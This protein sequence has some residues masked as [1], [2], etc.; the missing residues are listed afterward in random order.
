MIE[1]VKVSTLLKSDNKEIV[2]QCVELYNSHI[3][4]IRN[5]LRV[6]AKISL[7]NVYVDR[8]L[9]LID[10]IVAENV[11][12]SRKIELDFL[13][14]L[15]IL[16]N[17]LDR[18]YHRQK[19]L[20]KAKDK[21]IDWL[22]V[23]GVAGVGKST[24]QYEINKYYESQEDLSIT[25]LFFDS[26]R[27]D[28]MEKFAITL[29]L[30][31]QIK[32]IGG[33]PLII[34]DSIDV[35]GFDRERQDLLNRVYDLTDVKVLSIGRRNESQE[36]INSFTDQYLTLLEYDDNQ[37]KEAIQKYHSEYSRVNNDLTTVVTDSFA[38]I[39]LNNKS[40]RDQFRD[41]LLMNMAFAAYAP[42]NI[43]I[44]GTLNRSS[45]YA[46]FWNKIVEHSR[47]DIG[48]GTTRSNLLKF[49]AYC[50]VMK[51]NDQQMKSDL[52][53]FSILPS[54]GEIFQDILDSLFS[55]NLIT[56]NSYDTVSFFHDSFLTYAA[57]RYIVEGRS[58]DEQVGLRNLLIQ[59]MFSKPNDNEFI[60]NTLV[61]Y[62][63]LLGKESKSEFEKLL[64]DN[65]SHESED[66]P[67]RFC[68]RF[69]L[70][71]W[72]E[73]VLRSGMDDHD[74]QKLIDVY[75]RYQFMSDDIK[76]ALKRVE[77]SFKYELLLYM[78]KQDSKSYL[79]DLILD[80]FQIFD[81]EKIKMLLSFPMYSLTSQGFTITAASIIR[82][83]Q[84]ADDEA[85]QMYLK[86]LINPLFIKSKGRNLK[87]IIFEEALTLNRR[88]KVKIP[89][90]EL[91]RTLSDVLDSEDSK[92]NVRIE[93]LLAV[94]LRQD[95]WDEKKIHQVVDTLETTAAGDDL[96]LQCFLHALEK[97]IKKSS[98]KS[99]HNIM[100]VVDALQKYRSLNHYTI[101]NI[102]TDLISSYRPANKKEA[103][104][105]LNF[106]T[107]DKRFSDW[108][109]KRSACS[110][111][112]NVSEYFVDN[113]DVM[114]SNFWEI[115]GYNNQKDHYFQFCL[116]HSIIDNYNATTLEGIMP[117]VNFLDS[118]LLK[119]PKY[120]DTIIR[121]Q[122]TLFYKFEPT[123][124]DID[125]LL[126]LM[127]IILEKVSLLKKPELSNPI[128]GFVYIYE[129]K[130][131]NI[132][133][134]TS[135]RLKYIAKIGALINTF[136]LVSELTEC[137][138]SL[139]MGVVHSEFEELIKDFTYI[140]S[141]F[142]EEDIQDGS[143]ENLF[144]AM[145]NLINNYKTE[146]CSMVYK[147][148][149]YI[150][151]YYRNHS[152]ANIQDRY[153]IYL[154][155]PL[156]NSYIGSNANE[157]YDLLLYSIESF[158]KS[159]LELKKLYSREIYECSKRCNSL[160]YKKLVAP[161]NQIAS[162]IR[163]YMTD[164]YFTDL[165]DSIE[166]LVKRFTNGNCSEFINIL[167]NPLTVLCNVCSYR[168]NYML[169]IGSAVQTI[170]SQII[171][172]DKAVIQKVCR[173]I[174]QCLQSITFRMDYNAIE[175]EKK[176]I[177]NLFS[178]REID[179]MG[180][181]L[182][183][184]QVKNIRTRDNKNIA[185][186]L[187]NK[188]TEEKEN[189]LQ[190]IE[191]L[192]KKFNKEINN[193]EHKIK[194][195]NIVQISNSITLI[196]NFIKNPKIHCKPENVDAELM[197]TLVFHQI[198]L[199]KN[200]E[201]FISY[202]SE[203][204]IGTAKS[205]LKDILLGSLEVENAIFSILRE[206]AIFI[207]SADQYLPYDIGLHLLLKISLLFKKKDSNYL[208]E[209]LAN[210]LLKQNKNDARSYTLKLCELNKILIKNFSPEN[211]NVQ[212]MISGLLAFNDDF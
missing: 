178:E 23:D 144:A 175:K 183:E 191:E 57:A 131:E 133:L 1:R 56:S 132:N 38:D 208:A 212:I 28:C 44:D 22:H 95:S 49:I 177:V 77:R 157:L 206:I 60:I 80:D 129:Q 198:L 8:K 127:D 165:S 130:D 66:L 70:S 94:N 122:E 156:M 202:C 121:I 107:E 114:I 15:D 128:I 59:E 7:E 116:I 96:V 151:E 159:E 160:S 154:D 12:I 97:S 83:Y 181:I 204:S 115:L 139:A 21:K 211:E 99:F 17:G 182:P 113:C 40:L 200:D 205:L 203:S 10:K 187:M 18:E 64:M 11:T 79:M 9:L 46:V 118:I 29:D 207:D 173:L 31:T 101:D 196:K 166:E 4:D 126:Y 24:F 162:H 138:R 102:I 78:Q 184:Y 209:K 179:D 197:Y 61:E 2:H 120:E 135:L 52:N 25:P 136:G 69:S 164:I 63:L 189:I 42:N 146:D 149:D 145:G 13:G 30:I 167:E 148:F 45:V 90:K 169:G 84:P 109:W 140:D 92:L 50:K 106:A 124:N 185:V 210:Y 119:Y 48:N 35:P 111:L 155:K 82:C 36:L 73:I 54:K 20:L 93:D 5:R 110:C 43:P 152:Y 195:I 141:L 89:Y 67:F 33:T 137:I 86:Y 176:R 74:I 88:L 172:D 201:L 108:Q 47:Y 85:L 163:L 68:E 161:L 143:D 125:S 91:C 100:R 188:R 71:I 41:P 192:K 180:I 34:I 190:L 105:F 87:H 103:M 104:F 123:S 174:D 6:S 117:L 150:A 65:E 81:F 39:L 98:S 72:F 168:Q 62:G 158:G 112:S 193:I 194:D 147:M 171:T 58:V 16:I 32:G 134:K 199:V 26:A 14:V 76:L 27:K 75:S 170:V 53:N 3:S 51:K 37:I 55:D 19:G 186:S 153:H 142:G